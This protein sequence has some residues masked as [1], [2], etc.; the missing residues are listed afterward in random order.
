MFNSTKYEVKKFRE[1]SKEFNKKSNLNNQFPILSSS[2]AGIERQEDYFNKQVASEN[3]EGYKIVPR[4]FFTYRSMSDTGNFKFNIQ[5]IVEFGL[6]SPAYPVFEIISANPKYIYYLL[7]NSKDFLN[8][9]NRTK[10]G[11][12]R[13]ALSYEKLSSIEINLHPLEEQ[14]KIGSFLSEID[15]LIEKCKKR[16]LELLNLQKYH[17]KSLFKPNDS[18]YKITPLN[19]V[20]EIFDGTHQTPNYIDSGIPFV[21]VEDIKNLSLT[22]KYIT[23]EDFEKNFKKYPKKDDILMTRIGDIGTS[24]LFEE[25]YPIAFY[26]S[27]ALIKC[28]NIYPKFLNQFIKTDFFQKELNKRTIHA[29]FPK[30]INLSEIG[31]CMV[32]VPSQQVQYKLGEYLSNLNKLIKLERKKRELYEK[33]KKKYLERIFGE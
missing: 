32:I 6:V 21:S 18:N 16:D 11:G 14:Q 8:K 9:L 19:Q 15:N 4:G 2:I 13:F 7:N 28:K 5:D 25:N 24:E 22:S 31:N 26:V 17:L 30:K 27:L 3:N 20:A 33:V 29:A 23:K 1:I 10:Q 12:T